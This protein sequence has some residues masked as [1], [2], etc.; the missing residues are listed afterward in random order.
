MITRRDLALTIVVFACIVTFQSGCTHHRTDDPPLNPE[1]EEYRHKALRYFSK[2]KDD[3]GFEALRQA[4]LL[5]PEHPWA[6]GHVLMFNGDGKRNDLA[7]SIFQDA[8]KAKPD[9]EVA[10]HAIGATYSRMSRWDDAIAVYTERV[11]ITPDDRDVRY[12]LGALYLKVGNKEE[13]LNQYEALRDLKAWS[14][15]YSF[16]RQLYDRRARQLLECINTGNVVLSRGGGC[17][18]D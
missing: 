15:P 4:I 6:Y 5:A 16:E 12:E 1:A 13:A 7:V 14:W 10:L 18:S 11:R 9:S 2:H 3:E 8:L 17:S